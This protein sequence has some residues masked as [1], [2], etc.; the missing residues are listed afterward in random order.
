MEKNKEKNSETKESRK[1][2]RYVVRVLN[3]NDAGNA[4]CLLLLKHST[5]FVANRTVRRRRQDAECGGIGAVLPLLSSSRGGGISIS[6]TAALAV[7][8]DWICQVLRVQRLNRYTGK[9]G[10]FLW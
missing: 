6:T 8:R 2:P 3:A 10:W 7:L 5:S 9:H 1:K 4:L